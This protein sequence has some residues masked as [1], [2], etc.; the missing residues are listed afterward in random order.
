VGRSP[1]LRRLLV[2]I[3]L[4]VSAAF[5]Y[6]AVREVDFDDFWQALHQIRYWPSSRPLGGRRLNSLDAC[7]LEALVFFG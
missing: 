2:A 3:G 7:F 4:A 6:L 1:L 5:T